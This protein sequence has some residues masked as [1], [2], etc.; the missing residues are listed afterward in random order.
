MS[1]KLMM[2]LEFAK[3]AF[4]LGKAL[5]NAVIRGDER[6]VEQILPEELRTSIARKAAEAEALE[7][8]DS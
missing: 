5:M 6:R 4:V 2:G 3:D 1:D 8:F 7:K